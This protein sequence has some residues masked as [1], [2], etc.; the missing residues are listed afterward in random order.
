MWGLR[1][2][3]GWWP[4]MGVDGGQQW[5]AAGTGRTGFAPELPAHYLKTLLV[6]DDGLPT[7]LVLKC[8][9]VTQYLSFSFLF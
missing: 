4:R 1:V 5:A 3:L 9:S 7:S 8:P 6:W 2:G